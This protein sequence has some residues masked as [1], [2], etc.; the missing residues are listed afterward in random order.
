MSIFK[1]RVD[2]RMFGRA[3]ASDPS[4]RRYVMQA[5]TKDGSG[6]TKALLTCG[7]ITGPL[8]FAVAIIQAVTRPG[9]NIRLNAISQLSLG[10]IGWIQITSFLLTGLLAVACAVEC[11]AC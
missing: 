3:E 8:F 2:Y 5:A 1:L 10:D 7:V 9:Y 6:L 11:G 4:Q